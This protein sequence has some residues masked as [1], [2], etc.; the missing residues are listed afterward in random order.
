MDETRDL[1]TP[2][3]QYINVGLFN[4][5]GGKYGVFQLESAPTTNQLHLQFYVEFKKPVSLKAAQTA[6]GDFQHKA[7]MEVRK[8]SRDQARDYC[9]KKDTQVAGPWEIGDFEQG[10]P[11]TVDLREYLEVQP[12]E[13]RVWDGVEKKWL[14]WVRVQEDTYE[15][16]H[17]GF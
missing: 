13:F 1:S 15:L 10:R 3:E 17:E 5:M 16:Y 9:M 6:I 12:E 4:D 7:H 14:Q 11:A 2:L 8:G